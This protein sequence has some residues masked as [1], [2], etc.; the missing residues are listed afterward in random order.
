MLAQ[1]Y[2]EKAVQEI[3][4]QAEKI[5]LSITEFLVKDP[6]VIKELE[7][8]RIGPFRLSLK[9]AFVSPKN[10]RRLNLNEDEYGFMYG[11]KFKKAT[12]NVLSSKV[13]K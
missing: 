9:P 12:D 3:Q 4:K 11:I 8:R 13:K 10:Y 7:K 5:G 6:K 1:K 2:I